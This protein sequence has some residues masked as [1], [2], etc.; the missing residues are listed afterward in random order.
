M[1]PTR[2]QRL[3]HAERLFCEAAELAGPRLS[4]LARAEQL[5]TIKET[6]HLQKVFRAALEERAFKARPRP[7]V[8]PS[9][10]HGLKH[11][12]PR[13]GLFDISLRWG[14]LDVFGE[15]KCGEG[16]LTLSACGWDAAKQVF[17]MQHGVGAGMLLVAAAPTAMWSAGGIGIELFSDGE[18]DMADI[19]TRYAEGFRTWERDG[20]KPAYVFRRLRTFEAGRTEPFLIA[21]KPWLI[22]V[23]GVEPI[24]DERMDWVPFLQ[25]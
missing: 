20:Y 8:S 13:L 2:V 18:W 21:G 23:A 24:D 15:L 14:G 6:A 19:R 17:C 1:S 25:P 3:H 22:G 7:N 5:A 12:W 9:L 16:D 11:E 4:E 10:S